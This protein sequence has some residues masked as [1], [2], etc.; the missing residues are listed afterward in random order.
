MKLAKTDYDRV[1]ADLYNL[2][3]YTIAMAEAPESYGISPTVKARAIRELTDKTFVRIIR[4]IR[5]QRDRA[6][7]VTSN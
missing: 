3:T 1:Y 4:K 6:T 5:L 2:V 7:A